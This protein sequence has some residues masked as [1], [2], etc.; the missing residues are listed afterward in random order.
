MGVVTEFFHRI[1]ATS[2][3]APL[4]AVPAITRVLRRANIEP[5][6]VERSD[7]PKL[8]PSLEA[9]LLVYLEPSEVAARLGALREDSRP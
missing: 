8:L 9:C 5:S 7:L 1:V 3:L 6:T 4:I 2:G